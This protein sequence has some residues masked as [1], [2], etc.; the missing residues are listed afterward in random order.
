MKII[1]IDASPNL[2]KQDALLALQLLLSPWTWQSNKNT[3]LLK[4]YFDSQLKTTSTF[5]CQSGRAALYLILASILKQGEE[6]ITQAFTCLAVPNAISWA[7]GKPVFTDINQ[8]YNIDPADLIKKI[9]PKTKAIIIQHT[10]G[11]PADIDQVKKICQKNKILLIEDCAHALGAKYEGKFVGSFGDAAIFSFNQDKVVS[12]ISGGAAI[13][14]QSKLVGSFKK[15]AY[16]SD[17]SSL[18]ILKILL[19]PLIWYLALP[20]YESLNLG[21]GIIWLARQVGIFG[22]T[23][24]ELEENGNMPSGLL[25]TISEP[26]AELA[27]S[28]LKRLEKDNNRRRE[29]ASRYRSKLADLPIQHPIAADASIYLRYPIQVLDS[30]KLFKTARRKGIILGKW[31]NTPIF[32]WTRAAQKYYKLGSCPVAENVGKKVVNLPTSPRLLDQEVDK[33]INVVKEFYANN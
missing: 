7:G 23:I 5:L 11:I 20:I 2:Q 13:I 31:Y 27:M 24:T 32:P 1:A 19:H 8:T 17:V 14:R 12:G 4:N 28:G 25:K 16:L 10:F 6:V 21:K 15:K 33:I 29:I 3:N 26:Q 9:T 22:N 30:L 18:G